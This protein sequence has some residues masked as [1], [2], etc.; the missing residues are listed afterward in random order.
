MNIVITGNS[1][2]IGRMLTERLE[3]Q[4]HTVIGINRS[5]LLKCDVTDYDQVSECARYV[6][7]AYNSIDGLITCAGTQGEIGKM[8]KS[9]SKEWSQTIRVNLDGTYNAIRAFYPIMDMS[10]RPK[11]IC[12]AGGGAANGRPFF[13]AYAS[14]K[15]GV[16]RLVESFAMEE[17]G[18]DI[19][20]IAPG[21][22][23]TNI[24]KK[25]LELGPEVIGQDEYNKVIK[26]RDGGD[27]PTPMLELV[28][29]LLSE[30]SDGVTGRFISAKWDDWKTFKEKRIGSDDYKL[31][32]IV[33]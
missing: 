8:S 12:F 27:D 23:K 25:A 24:I 30:K 6:L 16:V 18:A 5:G 28:D 21:A 29:W 26:Q 17:T 7:D 10:R 33:P 1:S 22:I 19:N 11:I 3:N 20:A 32:R 15:A 14:A 31:R 9:S 13:S 4:G 2:G